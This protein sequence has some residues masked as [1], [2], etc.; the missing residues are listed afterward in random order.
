MS[1]QNRIQGST[2]F[3]ILVQE[4]DKYMGY[5]PKEN[6]DKQDLIQNEL[7]NGISNI[8]LTTRSSR[9]CSHQ[10]IDDHRKKRKPYTERTNKQKG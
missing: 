7:G 9:I 5:N 4:A 1:I 6:S 3:K 10:S 2:I 8:L